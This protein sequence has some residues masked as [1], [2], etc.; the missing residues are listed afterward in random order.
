MDKE[1]NEDLNYFGNKAKN[2]IIN[3]FTEI[4]KEKSLIG[5][6]GTYKNS[7]KINIKIHSS[8]NINFQDYWILV[9]N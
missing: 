6:F 4:L 2:E 8:K 1:A 9:A 7:L 5:N 3:C